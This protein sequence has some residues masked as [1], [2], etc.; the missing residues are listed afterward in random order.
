MIPQR[1]LD[2]QHLWWDP[3]LQYAK[4]IVDATCGNGHDT[5]YLAEHSLGAAHIYG[6]DLQPQAII[7]TNNRV[8]NFSDKVTLQQISHDSGIQNIDDEIDL[9]VF[10][11]GYLPGSN[12]GCMT[13][14]S[15]TL[16]ALSIGLEKLSSQGFISV[17]AYP[18]TD[19]GQREYESVLTWMQSLDQKKYTAFQW[20]PLNQVNKPPIYLGI[21]KR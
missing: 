20:Q 9:I 13:S 6:F 7:N 1:A 5:L 2:V 16:H 3:V 12:H 11:L 14:E 15:T 21:L 19:E 4:V 8:A 10:N 18:G 17:V